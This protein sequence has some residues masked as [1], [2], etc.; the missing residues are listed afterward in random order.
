MTDRSSIALSNLTV[1]VWFESVEDPNGRTD[2]HVKF[3]GLER[4]N[5]EEELL[6]K[7]KILSEL[8]YE[9][10]VR[11]CCEEHSYRPE[12]DYTCSCGHFHAEGSVKVPKRTE[13]ETEATPDPDVSWVAHET[14]QFGDLQ[15][16]RY[17]ATLFAKGLRLDTKESDLYH[18]IESILL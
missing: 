11:M 16:P 7:L 3:F 15:S 13:P 6:E 8:G 5:D 2:G 4:E 10:F 17:A 12:E 9:R 1:R 18:R 14:L